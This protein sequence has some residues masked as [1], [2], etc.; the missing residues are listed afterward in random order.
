M[1]NSSTRWRSDG[2]FTVDA[3][4]D[5][6]PHHRGDLETVTFRIRRSI[7][8]LICS[9]SVCLAHQRHIRA[10]LLDI[11]GERLYAERCSPS[12]GISPAAK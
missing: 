12:T 9:R 8:A 3:T 1:N 10:T 7:R 5:T 6:G 11:V 2:A 4:A